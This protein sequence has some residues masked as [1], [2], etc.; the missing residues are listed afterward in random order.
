MSL[1]GNNGYIWISPIILDDHQQEQMR[2][3]LPSTPGSSSVKTVTHVSIQLHVL[4][5]LHI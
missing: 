1:L 5:L 3:Q 2:F 4:Q